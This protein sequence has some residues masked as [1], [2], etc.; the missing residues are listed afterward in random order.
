MNEIQVKIAD[1]KVTN[2]DNKLIT[3][4]LGSCVGVTLYSPITKV[5]GLAHIMLPDS[6]QFSKVTNI[7]KF[8]DLAL[9][10]MLE[11]ML[12]MGV[13][14]AGIN[15]G[16]EKSL[17]DIGRRNIE[18][19]KE[20]LH[21]LGLKLMAEDVGGNKGRTMIFDT[22]TGLVYIRTIGSPIIEI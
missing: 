4:G 10:A 11:D 9:P 5:G 17:L 1:Y 2:N 20:Q 13:S 16:A 22:K 7:A 21:K 3:L 6:T 14:R 15:Y 19:V 18:A 12:K 8:A